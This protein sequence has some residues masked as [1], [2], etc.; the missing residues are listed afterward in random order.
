VKSKD[1]ATTMAH[2]GP[3]SIPLVPRGDFSK[4]RLT[5]EQLDTIWRI[6]GPSATINLA[7][8]P[9]WIVIC[10]AYIEGLNHG[11]GLEEERLRRGYYGEKQE[12]A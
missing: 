4:L 7:K 11:H 8:N 3:C 6:V 2:I 5:T 1:A 12:G 9:L 10:M